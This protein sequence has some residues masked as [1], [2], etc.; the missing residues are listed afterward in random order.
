MAV[1]CVKTIFS[2]ITLCAGTMDNYIKV[3]E[4]RQVG[5][6]FNGPGITETF[7]LVSEFMGKIEVRNP[8]AR[9]AGVGIEDG[10]THIVYIPFDQTIYEMDNGKLFIEIE[11]QKNRRFKL[12]SCSN[13][14]EQDSYLAL[15]CRETGF[16]DKEAAGA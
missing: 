3:L 9:F 5:G 12:L 7:T 2:R 10:V 15:Y 6:G 4:R 1:R 14:D 13:L 8:T 16:V 11:R